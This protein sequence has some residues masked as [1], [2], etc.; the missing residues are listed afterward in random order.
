MNFVDGTKKTENV[1]NS[2]LTLIK[3]NGEKFISQ[4]CI[5]RKSQIYHET[6]FWR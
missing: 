1:R 5:C 4:E 6:F 3:N 2:Y